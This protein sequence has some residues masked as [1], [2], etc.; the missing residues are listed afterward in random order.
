MPQVGKM[1]RTI[2]LG[3]AVL[4]SPTTSHEL[5][6][7]TLI[8]ISPQQ[9]STN[10]EQYNPPFLLDLLSSGSVWVGRGNG[11]HIDLNLTL[12]GEPLG[13][14]HLQELANRI[15]EA[16]ASMESKPGRPH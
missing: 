14:R 7:T 16:P 11:L 1:S 2:E 6:L 5:W 4:S 3:R 12:R 15:V 9:N 8:T 13:D 10:I